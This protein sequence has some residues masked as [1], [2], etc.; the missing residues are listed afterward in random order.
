MPKRCPRSPHIRLAVFLS[1]AL[2]TLGVSAEE[3]S[4]Q[5]L[6]SAAKGQKI[7]FKVCVQCH[8]LKD[9]NQASGPGL[10]GVMERVPSEKWVMQW[11]KD[12]EALI[13]S[14]DA[15]AKSIAGEYPVEMPKLEVMQQKSNREA[16]ITFLKRA[17]EDP[18]K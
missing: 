18:M 6:A 3:A 12:P 10:E 17:R 4:A 9:K 1:A 8:T 11:L 16:V 2:L 5:S 13:K 14:G 7:F 15:Y